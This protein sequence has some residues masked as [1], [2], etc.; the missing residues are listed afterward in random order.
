MDAPTRAPGATST[1]TTRFTTPTD[2]SQN[3]LGPSTTRTSARIPSTTTIDPATLNGFHSRIATTE[4]Q[5]VV[6]QNS[7]PGVGLRRLLLPVHGNQVATDNTLVTAADYDGPFCVVAPPS[8][9]LPGGGGYQVCG[10]YDIKPTAPDD[11]NNVTLA[12][13]FGGVVDRYMG[14][15]SA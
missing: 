12:R 13:N 5:A 2:P 15:I 7:L 10:L 6:Q 3:E 1:A 8:P 9:D 11:Q 4:W 14:S